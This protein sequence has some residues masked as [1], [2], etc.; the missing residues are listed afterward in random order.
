M[1]LK[2]PQFHSSISVS[3]S[4]KEATVSRLWKKGV[5]MNQA[6]INAFLYIY[7]F[8]YTFYYTY[9]IV[10]KAVPKLYD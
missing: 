8:F 4:M 1:T 6:I 9:T 7:I 2:M 5:K 3:Y 10:K